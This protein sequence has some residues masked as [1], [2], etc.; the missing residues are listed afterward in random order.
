[1]LYVRSIDMAV[2]N[3]RLSRRSI[4]HPAILLSSQLHI[5][6]QTYGYLHTYISYIYIISTIY[7]YSKHTPAIRD[8]NLGAPWP[9]LCSYQLDRHDSGDPATKVSYQIDLEAKLP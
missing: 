7:I 5:C 4:Y 6:I 8:R 2:H 3:Q 1:M 9:L